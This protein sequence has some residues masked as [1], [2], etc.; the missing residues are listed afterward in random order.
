MTENHDDVTTI[1]TPGE[2]LTSEP[3]PPAAPFVPPTRRD[4]AHPSLFK[5]TP[6]RNEDWFDAEQLEDLRAYAKPLRRLR[7]ASSVI[8]TIVIVAFVLLKAGPNLVDALD[9][10][11]WWLK[12]LV[13]STAFVLVSL[14]FDIP[15]S[16]YVTLNYDRR[17]GV[18]NVT[19]PLFIKDQIKNTVLGI[20]MNVV[21]LTPVYL[22][23]R[24]TEQWWLFGGLGF[25]ALALVFAF[26]YPVL[27]LP[28]FNKFTPMP[29][30]ALR[31]R[32]EQ[33]AD[34][35]GETIEGVYLMDGS[36]RSRRGNAFV[37][38]FGK[39]KRVVVFDTI[40]DWPL[41]EVSQVVAHEIGHYRLKH[42]IRDFPLTGLQMMATLAIVQLI[43]TNDAILRWAGI[44][45][46]ED[47]AG[48]A[49]F[50]LAFGLASTVIS[51][52]SAWQSRRREREADLEALELLGNPSA[53]V[54]LWPKFAE[55][56]KADLEPSWWSK[57]NH[58]H[59][60]IGERMAFGRDWA[61]LNNV[62][63]EAPEASPVS[64]PVAAE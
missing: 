30:G 2:A 44:D 41:D 36:K 3:T 54:A 43:T 64:K 50:L 22:A 39:T 37:A 63:F 27:I 1:E 57:L 58:S 4:S 21:L 48:F 46:I 5:N 60:Q 6:F 34:L 53:F 23:I 59:P 49:L 11:N 26:V 55:V 38:G 12:L 9:V 24:T 18:S 15:F 32:I 20:V 7:Q 17:H 35:A 52:F 61:A 33:V 47:P 14:P 25:L 8:S 13:V 51:L 62:E 19:L 56:N 10:T 28:R 45:D 31:T 29:E 40:A 42:I 16:A